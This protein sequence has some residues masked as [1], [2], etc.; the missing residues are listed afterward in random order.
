M[1]LVFIQQ[2][3][4]LSYKYFKNSN[5]KFVFD[6]DCLLVSRINEVSFVVLLETY[7]TH[8]DVKMAD[9]NRSSQVLKIDDLCNSP[10]KNSVSFSRWVK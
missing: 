7:G 1:I 5:L 9:R 10:E 6:C 8:R 4:T 2:C 3:N